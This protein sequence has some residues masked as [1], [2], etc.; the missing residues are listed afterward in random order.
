[1]TEAAGAD[2]APIDVVDDVVRAAGCDPRRNVAETEIKAGLPP[3]SVVRTRSI[4]A[5]PH[6]PADALSDHVIVRSA[7]VLDVASVRHIFIDR[8][9]L[10]QTEETSAG[11]RHRIQIS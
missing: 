8:V 7:V 2:S 4:A 1:M 5:H 9:C 6:G 11:L 3:D 10:L